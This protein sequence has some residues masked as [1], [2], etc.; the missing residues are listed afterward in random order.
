MSTGRVPLMGHLAALLKHVTYNHISSHGKTTRI[1]VQVT[2]QIIG[3]YA[4]QPPPSA[5]AQKPL[6]GYPP[7]SE[8]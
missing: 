4:V 6:T 2:K 5:N 3:Q 7:N 8:Q 1:Y